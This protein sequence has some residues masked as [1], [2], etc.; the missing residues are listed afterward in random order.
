M[1]KKHIIYGITIILAII[2]YYIFIPSNK[3]S[4]ITEPPIT[5]NS[6]PSSNDSK[7]TQSSKTFPFSEASHHVGQQITISGTPLKV[8]RSRKGTVFF[9]Y[10]NDY[11]TCSFNAV[12]FPADV[13]K[14]GDITKYQEKNINMTGMIRNYKGEAGMILKDINQIELVN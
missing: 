11:K 2:A 10:C 5:I 8:Y 13:Y 14:F 9:D 6:S 4:A 12:I 7:T 3:S 1:N